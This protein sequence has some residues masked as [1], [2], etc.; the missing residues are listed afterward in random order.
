VLG[1]LVEDDSGPANVVGLG[2]MCVL[3]KGF[4]KGRKCGSSPVAL[5]VAGCKVLD[6][7][8]FALS[9]KGHQ[10]IECILQ[11]LMIS[12]AFDGFE[13]VCGCCFVKSLTA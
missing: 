1:K 11:P 5:D 6:T 12:R 7:L 2:H 9:K 13:S 8:S 3:Q 10:C 4:W